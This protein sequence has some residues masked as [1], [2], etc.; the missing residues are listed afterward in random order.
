MIVSQGSMNLG[1]RLRDLDGF[2]PWQILGV[3]RGTSWGDTRAAYHR[4][5]KA[6]HPDRYATAE[7][8][9]EV[10]SYLSGMARR[11][12][13]AYSA[14]EASQAQKRQYAGKRQEPIFTTP[15]RP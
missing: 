3:E 9:D 8:P 6:Y 14:L 11:V 5:A 15:A 1:Q 13:A 4:L 12:N 7:L 10:I 2:D